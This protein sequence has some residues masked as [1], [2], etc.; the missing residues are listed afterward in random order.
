MIQVLMAES[1]KLRAKDPDRVLQL[2]RFVA[3]RRVMQPLHIAVLHIVRVAGGSMVHGLF[4]AGIA[5]HVHLCWEVTARRKWDLPSNG[6]ALGNKGSPR[7]R[8]QRLSKHG[9][10]RVCQCF[11]CEHF[12]PQR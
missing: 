6:P 7:S 10:L 5:M 2:L 12:F 8:G 11:S 9:F 4:S 1:L 3:F